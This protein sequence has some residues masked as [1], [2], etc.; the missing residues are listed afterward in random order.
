MEQQNATQPDLPTQTSGE[1][2]DESGDPNERK[3]QHEARASGFDTSTKR[4]RVIPATNQV[5]DRV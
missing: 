4:K 2:T 5:I 1:E 3:Y